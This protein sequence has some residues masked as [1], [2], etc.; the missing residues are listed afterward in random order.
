MFSFFQF[1]GECSTCSKSLHSGNMRRNFYQFPMMIMI[2]L[3]NQRL[4][5]KIGPFLLLPFS[6]ICWN[7][8]LQA[9]ET[10]KVFRKKNICFLIW[11]H[12]K[13]LKYLAIGQICYYNLFSCNTFRYPAWTPDLNL[14]YPSDIRGVQCSCLK[15]W[16]ETVRGL[17]AR[18]Y[19]CLLGFRFLPFSVSPSHYWKRTIMKPCCDGV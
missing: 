4:K 14:W 17:F 3:E 18:G 2:F 8:V 9:V 10:K 13:Y 5:N 15:V 6:R 16:P 1:L 7:K 11:I 19:F 12:G